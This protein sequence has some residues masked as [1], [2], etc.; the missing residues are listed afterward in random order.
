MSLENIVTLTVE[1]VIAI[2][3]EVLS[4]SG[5]L[6]GISPDKSLDGA[7]HRVINHKFAG[8]PNLRGHNTLFRSLCVAHVRRVMLRWTQ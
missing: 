7:L 6:P 8:T 1:A 5:G 2:H 4:E 3:D